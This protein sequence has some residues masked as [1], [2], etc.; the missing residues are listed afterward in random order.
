MAS[1]A[2]TTAIMRADKGMS[3]PRSVSSWQGPSYHTRTF[4]TMLR[5]SGA[6][7]VKDLQAHRP[8]VVHHRRLLAVQDT[9]LEQDV[10]RY[11]DHADVVQQGGDFQQ[12]ALAL[13]QAQLPRPRRTGQGDAEAVSRRGGVLALQGGEQAAHHSQPQPDQPR[14]GR[15]AGERR[16]LPAGSRHILQFFQERSQLGDPMLHGHRRRH[17][18]GVPRGRRFQRMA[19]RSWRRILCG[20]N[21]AF[22]LSNLGHA[23]TCVKIAALWTADSE[24]IPWM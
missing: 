17:A 5:I 16:R 1:K 4:S 10:I 22:S 12:I 20:Q 13:L 9:R 23:K 2:S 15:L 11:A 14:F 24:P 7:T 18:R 8:A 21:P 19:C 3:S 6:A